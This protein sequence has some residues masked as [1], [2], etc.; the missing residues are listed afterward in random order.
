M[1]VAH[2]TTS[3]W[4]TANFLAF[5]RTDS[6]LPSGPLTLHQAA[7]VLSIFYVGSIVGNLAAPCVV[8]K[9]GCKR[10]MMVIA[11][12][13]IVREFEWWCAWWRGTIEFIAILFFQLISLLAIFAQNPYYLYAGSVI[14]G[15]VGAGQIISMPL[16]VTEISFD[17]WA[18]FI[19][20]PG[21]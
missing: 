21:V 3:S 7:L 2:G 17:K 6:A 15:L 11:I 12:P 8:R 13:Q 20:Q 10:V 9:F 16:F 4:P 5:L 1:T 19:D 14:G 18:L